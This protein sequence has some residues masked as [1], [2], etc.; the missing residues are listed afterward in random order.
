MENKSGIVGKFSGDGRIVRPAP[1]TE[2]LSQHFEEEDKKIKNLRGKF[3]NDA[4]RIVFEP[5]REFNRGGAR[6]SDMYT[7][8]LEKFAPMQDKRC[9]DVLSREILSPSVLSF[10]KSWPVFVTAATHIIFSTAHFQMPYNINPGNQF[11]P[12]VHA[13]CLKWN[14]IRTCRGVSSLFH[15]QIRLTTSQPVVT[16]LRVCYCHANRL[17]EGRSCS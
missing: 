17:R 4:P 2:P 6:L 9:R 3:D 16:L 10:A 14:I 1:V 8:V 11:Y 13:K 15:N 12:D 5:R 7:D